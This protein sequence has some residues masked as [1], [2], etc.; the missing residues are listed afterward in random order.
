MVQIQRPEYGE[1]EI[2]DLDFDSP[3]EEWRDYELEDGTIL[4]VK[5]V[6]NKIF[7]FED[8]H[9]SL[10]E[11]VYQISTQNIVRASDIPEESMGKPQTESVP[12][13]LM[14]QIQQATETEVEDEDNGD[15]D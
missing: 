7:R 1:V 3:D 12:E 2:T 6:V 9:T 13:E 10:G 8:Q 14:N 11:P 5:T 15:G 4:K